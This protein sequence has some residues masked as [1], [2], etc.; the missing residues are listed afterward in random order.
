MSIHEI[1][2]G[3]TAIKGITA[4]GVAA[5]I[6]K[7]K[8]RDLALIYSATP[9]TVAGV[10]TKNRCPA[11]SI[12]F[13]KAR[14]RKRQG[15]AI[16]AN[17]GNANAATGP[18]GMED[19]KW[20]ARVTAQS[21]GIPEHLVYV[22]STGVIGEPLP[23]EKIQQALPGLTAALSKENGRAA[24]EA[25]MT[26]DK[27]VKEFAVEGPVGQSRIKIGGITKGSGMVHPNMATMLAFLATDA[28]VDPALLQEGLREVTH[29]TFNAI[30]VDGDTSTN[31]LVL[32]FASGQKGSLIN[33]KGKPYQQFLAL[34]E[35]ACSRLAQMIVQD[36]EGAT[37]FITV[38]V[39]GA[40]HD[41]AARQIASSIARSN[42]VKTAFFGQDTNWGR[43]VAAMGNAGVAI[44]LAKLD[45]TFGKIPLLLKGMHQGKEVEAEVNAYLKNKE[46]MLSV[47]LH[48][49]AGTATFWTSDLS[50]DYIRI[51][52]AY[53]S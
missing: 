51:N 52:A 31:D 19:T 49:G 4:S 26:T 9:C 48:E 3:I 43:I 50:E 5:G 37:K 27:M 18:R 17:S 21:L 53:R 24:A 15:Q 6:K 22:A 45:I 2:G 29:R 36:G 12:Q 30:T 10:F 40:T 28:S 34:L 32:L 8:Q 25:I 20:M 14:L 7:N 13:N 23:V 1:P 11:S 39:I 41:R 35:A 47:D 33:Q 16:I 38:Q 44:N 42:L 46:L